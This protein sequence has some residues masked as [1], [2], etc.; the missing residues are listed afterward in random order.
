M[1]RYASSAQ[2]QAAYRQQPH[3]ADPELGLY[4]PALEPLSNLHGPERWKS[5]VDL[6]ARL[7][8][9]IAEEMNIYADSRCER[10]HDD[11]DVEQRFWENLEQVCTIH[12]QL[13]DLKCNF[14]L[15]QSQAQS[16]AE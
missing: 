3:Q 5:A 1:R 6:A 16:N 12:G 7:L 14:Y 13:D 8:E 9:N 2:R 10:W 15:S 11:P 4:L